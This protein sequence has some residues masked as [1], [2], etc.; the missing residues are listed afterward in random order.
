METVASLLRRA[1]RSAFKSVSRSVGRS[2]IRVGQLVG[3]SVSWSVSRSVGW[4]VGQL[5][6]QLVGQ[7]VSR[8]VGRSVSMLQAFSDSGVP[9]RFRHIESL[10]CIVWTRRE[11]CSTTQTTGRLRN[12]RGR[13]E[14]HREAE[15]AQ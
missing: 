6:G 1:S 13:D 4:S 7:S 10:R 8:S 9:D 15:C 3:Q 5:V 12:E 2:G 14:R 11:P